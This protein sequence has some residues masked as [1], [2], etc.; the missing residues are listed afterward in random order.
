MAPAGW[1]GGSRF[2]SPYKEN[3]RDHEFSFDYKEARVPFAGT[4]LYPRP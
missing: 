4:C 1:L 2:G 3:A